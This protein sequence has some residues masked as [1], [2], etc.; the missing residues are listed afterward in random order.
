M[1]IWYVSKAGG[2]AARIAQKAKRRG[3]EVVLIKSGDA[4]GVVAVLGEPGLP[5]QGARAQGLR[6]AVRLRAQPKAEAR[7]GAAT[8]APAGPTAS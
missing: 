3:I 7:V 1:W 2:S 6:L 5:A 4:L 8:A